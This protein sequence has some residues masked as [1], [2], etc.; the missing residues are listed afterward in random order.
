MSQA[1]AEPRFALPPG[2]EATAPPEARGLARDEVRMAVVAPDHTHHRQAKELP[3]WL[4][5]GDL[6][7]VNTSATLPSALEVERHGCT[8]GLHVSAELDDGAWV[9]ELRLPG[10]AGPGVPDPGEVLRLPGGVR[11]RVAEPH[12]PGQSR[13]WRATALPAVDRVAYLRRHGAPIRYP[14]LQHA[15]PIEDLQNVYATVPGSAEMPSAGR[16]L[17]REVLVDL[18][19]LGI[20]VAPLVLHTGVA[21]QESHEPPQPEWLSVPEP[22]ARLVNLTQAAG[23]RVVAVGTTVVRALESAASAQGEVAAYDGWTSLVLSSARPARVV[24]GLLTG[25]H[26]PEASHLDLLESV[27]GRALVDRAYADITEPGAPHYLWH[28]FGDSMLLLP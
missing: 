15:W 19:S 12:P 14:Y 17:S 18:M 3:L 21:S 6:L 2:S 9:V 11:L 20:V 1:A 22:T 10:N 7:V 26:E 23:G 28:E 25:L 27:A 13:L 24:S 5:P 16:P 8:W 4:E